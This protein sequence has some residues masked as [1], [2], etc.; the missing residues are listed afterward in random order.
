MKW[1]F[2]EMSILNDN[3]SATLFVRTSNLN[4]FEVNVTKYLQSTI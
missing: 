2:I 1:N 3:L 4:H